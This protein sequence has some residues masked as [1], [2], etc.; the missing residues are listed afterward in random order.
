MIASLLILILLL[1][2]AQPTGIGVKS[3]DWAI[4]Q[5][6]FHQEQMDNGNVNVNI[7]RNYL[8][9]IELQILSVDGTHLTYKQTDRLE[10]GSVRL[11][12]T[13]TVDPT[14]PIYPTYNT[15]GILENEL[16][17]MLVPSGLGV[18]DHLPQVIWLPNKVGDS[19][20]REWNQWVNSTTYEG[21]SLNPMTVNHVEWSRD[22]HY[23]RDSYVIDFHEDSQLSFDQVTGLMLHAVIR[24]ELSSHSDYGQ[25]GGLNYIYD[26]RLIDSSAIPH[27]YAI[28][29]LTVA[30]LMAAVLFV[31][32]PYRRH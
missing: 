25:V 15:S 12:A 19:V 5:K 8:W 26:Y 10:N 22:I 31:L 21:D 29:G 2:V 20:P 11:Q 14:K 3:G 28:A 13:Y 6:R 23:V 9:I 18:G 4:Y 7:N 24:E 1:S 16:N 17:M 32:L 30:T 27:N